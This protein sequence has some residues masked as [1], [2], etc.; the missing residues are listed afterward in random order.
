[1]HNRIYYLF[2]TIILFGN[3]LFAQNPIIRNQYSADPS[4]RIFGDKVYLFPSHDIIATD[5]LFGD[6]NP[7]GKLPITFYRDTTQ[8]PG[9]EDYTM[10]GRTYRYMTSDPLFPFGYGLSYTNFSIGNAQINKNEIEK[11]ESIQLTVPVSN[12]GEREGTEVVQVYVRKANDSSGLNKTLRGFQRI[13][14]AAGKTTNAIVDLPYSSFEFYDDAALQLK[15]TPGEYEIFY[16]SSSDV[17]DLKT[18][19]VNIK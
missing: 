12:T 4:A 2:V 13:N 10:K 8:F 11:N 15:V 1:M 16:G 17:K 14:V 6:Y 5:I 3:F 9:F 18:I 7:S 19:R